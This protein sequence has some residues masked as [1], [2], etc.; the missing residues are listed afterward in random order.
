M[1]QLLDG[2][3]CCKK[4]LGCISMPKRVSNSEYTGE[5]KKGTQKVRSVTLPKQIVKYLIAKIIDY[6]RKTTRL[7]TCGLFCSECFERTDTSSF[8]TGV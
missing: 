8:G 4:R 1:P 3:I 5:L 2:M 6:L 7:K